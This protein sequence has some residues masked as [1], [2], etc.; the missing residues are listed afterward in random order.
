MKQRLYIVID[1]DNMPS[2][3]EA[4]IGFKLVQALNHWRPS[5]VEVYKSYSAFIEAREGATK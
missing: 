1:V 3:T 5:N 2:T 4:E